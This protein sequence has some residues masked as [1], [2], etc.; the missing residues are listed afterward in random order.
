MDDRARTKKER[1]DGAGGERSQETANQTNEA[2]VCRQGREPA[3]VRSEDDV[4][5]RSPKGE[6]SP[7]IQEDE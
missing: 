3:F 6:T 2:E 5:Y 1:E 7:F 4:G